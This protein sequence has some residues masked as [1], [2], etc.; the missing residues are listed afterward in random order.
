VGTL[1]VTST[2]DLR[3]GEIACTLSHVS[4][5]RRAAR[6]GA[7]TLAVFE[8][9]CTLSD[10]GVINI[11]AALQALRSDAAFSGTSCAW[12]GATPSR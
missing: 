3:A 11:V 9:D 10:A 1:S 12:A 6:S 4:P 5:W 8:D 2:A 7:T